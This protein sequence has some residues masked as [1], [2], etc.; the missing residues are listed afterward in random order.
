[1]IRNLINCDIKKTKQNKNKIKQK[2]N[3]NKNKIKNKQ[4]NK[5][6]KKQTNKTKN[7]NKKLISAGNSHA[8]KLKKKKKQVSP[9]QNCQYKVHVYSV[10]GLCSYLVFMINFL[11][12]SRPSLFSKSYSI[13]SAVPAMTN[14]QYFSKQVTFVFVF[15]Y[16]NIAMLSTA[17]MNRHK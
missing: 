11:G 9:Y 10:E 5:Q 6:N 4:T 12:R 15:T 17:T 13:T 1:M 16:D 14:S 8:C 2:Q 3:K 7:K